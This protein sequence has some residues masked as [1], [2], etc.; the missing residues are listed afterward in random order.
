M[1]RIGLWDPV[2]LG[3]SAFSALGLGEQR[4]NASPQMRWLPKRTSLK[5]HSTSQPGS[6]APVQVRFQCCQE[7]S[8]MQ[9]KNLLKLFFPKW[10][11]SLR[12]MG[13]VS[14]TLLL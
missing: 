13:L 5:F 1:R 8:E 11:P 3:M 7:P 4:Q 10:Y 2:K 6:K 9:R 12:S 14:G